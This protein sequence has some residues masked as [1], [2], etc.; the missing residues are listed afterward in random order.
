[1]RGQSNK[2]RGVVSL[3][4][5]LIMMVV[6]TLIVLGFAEISRNEQR[7]TLDDQLSVQA[8]YAA[9]SGINDARSVINAAV[10]G[11]T[12]VPSKTTCDNQGSYNLN[13]TVDSTHGVA[14]TCVLVDPNPTSLVYNNVGSQSVVVPIIASSGTFSTITLK[15]EAASSASSSA[16]NCYASGTSPN[17]FPV[18][19]G[20]GQWSCAYP[21]VRVDMLDA[22]AGLSRANWGN[23]TATFFGVPFN[24]ATG[25]ISNNVDLSA[26]G[27]A[28]PASCDSTFCTL[29]ITGLSGSTYYMRVNTVYS[30]TGKLIISAGGKAFTGAQATID[31]TGKAQDVIRRVLV[32]VDLTDANAYNIPNAAIVSEDSACKRFGVANGFFEVYDDLSS[33]G[34]GNTLCTKQS[35]G[36]PTP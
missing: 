32:A 9:E 26:R 33:G 15:W 24:S 16:T 5:T 4:V 17:T 22:N 28:V 18:A 35:S 29:N 34:G 30:T 11:G 25:V 10:T 1:M 7:S 14:Y 2:Q 3:M 19:S 31:S 6:I 12:A 8:Y 13:T 36:S 23:Q 20:A 27:K 21:V